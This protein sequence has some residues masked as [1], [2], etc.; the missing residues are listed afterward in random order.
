MQAIMILT[1]K[2]LFLLIGVS[3]AGYWLTLRKEQRLRFL[4]HFAVAGVLAFALTK[5]AGIC[6][7]NPRPFV[8]HHFMPLIPH[9]P[10]NGFPSDH[11]VLSTLIAL[12]VLKYSRIV[13]IVLLVLALLVGWSRVFVG[14]HTPIDIAGALMIAGLA[15]ICA[16]LILQRFWPAT[17][18]RKEPSPPDTI[19]TG[20]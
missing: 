7:D 12:I 6:F 19:I 10:D 13:G 15:A 18:V 11:T 14:V 1:A 8:V 17:A 5:L 4:L 20:G 16:A 9:D 3:S 2:Y